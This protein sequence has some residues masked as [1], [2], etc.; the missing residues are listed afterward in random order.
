MRD[1]ERRVRLRGAFLVSILYLR[2]QSINLLEYLVV[3]GFNSLFEM[4]VARQR[5]GGG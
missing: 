2:C 1:L 3:V 5:E 4:Q